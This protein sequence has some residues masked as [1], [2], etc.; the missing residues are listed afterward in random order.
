[1]KFG[2]VRFSH[3]REAEEAIKGCNGMTIKKGKIQVTW[4][5]F[6]NDRDV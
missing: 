1:M 4:A 2:L 5:K 3:T 6:V